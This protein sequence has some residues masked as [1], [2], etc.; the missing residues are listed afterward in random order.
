MKYNPRGHK[1]LTPLHE[2]ISDPTP[3]FDR[4]YDCNASSSH[5]ARAITGRSWTAGSISVVVTE[6]AKRPGQDPRSAPILKKVKH[7][8]EVVLLYGLLSFVLQMAS[9]RET[10]RELSRPA[11]L[12]TVQELEPLPH[13]DTHHRLLSEIDVSQLEHAHVA[14]IRRLIGHKKFRRSLIAHCYPIAIDGTQKRVRTGP[15]WAE[16]GLE[17]RRDTADGETV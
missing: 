16:E 13:A 1:Q 11:F 3:F 15:W 9:R 5:H 14:V 12:A 17:R 8:L 10:N 2:T 7:K 4:N 6:A